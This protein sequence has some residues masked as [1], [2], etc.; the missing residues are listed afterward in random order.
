M[1]EQVQ[2]VLRLD[3]FAHIGCGLDPTF[4]LLVEQHHL[5]LALVHRPAEATQHI[6]NERGEA[7]VDELF[8]LD[9]ILIE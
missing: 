8:V 4:A 2:L 3:N 5:L 7:R 1:L 9:D 6:V